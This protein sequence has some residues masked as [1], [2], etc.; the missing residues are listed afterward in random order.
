MMMT[1]GYSEGSPVI[2]LLLTRQS[3]ADN[4][5]DEQR[6]PFIWHRLFP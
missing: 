4:I 2:D 5:N 1:D 6:A 3:A